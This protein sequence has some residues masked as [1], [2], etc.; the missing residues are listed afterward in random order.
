MLRIHFANNVNNFND[1]WQH[2]YLFVFGYQ[3][4]PNSIVA[5][6]REYFIRIDECYVI[7]ILILIKS[8]HYLT[9]DK[10]HPG[11]KE[12]TGDIVVVTSTSVHLPCLGICH[13]KI[14]TM[15]LYCI[16]CIHILQGCAQVY[17]S[18]GYL[19]ALNLQNS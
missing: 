11:V 8:H 15:K 4:L 6:S 2:I 14:H 5:N 18:G 7:C 13:N 3:I 10:V 19:G 1:I 9:N 17:K 12:N 16:Q